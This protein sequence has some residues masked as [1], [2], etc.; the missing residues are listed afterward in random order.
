MDDQGVLRMTG[1]QWSTGLSV[2]M[3]RLFVQREIAT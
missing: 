1:A 3:Y 2:T